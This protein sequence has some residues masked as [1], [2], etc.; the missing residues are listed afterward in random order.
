LAVPVD[1][2]PY[3]YHQQQ[4]QT[5]SEREFPAAQPVLHNDTNAETKE[6]DTNT[7]MPILRLQNTVFDVKQRTAATPAWFGG[8]EKNLKIN[9]MFPSD[10]RMGVQAMYKT[11]L[12]ISILFLSLF[13]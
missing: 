12:L 6:R 13:S 1:L 7:K 8:I 10:K 11:L 4:Y 5:K 3:E 2:F 9:A